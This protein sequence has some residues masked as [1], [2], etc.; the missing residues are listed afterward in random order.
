[1]RRAVV[2]ASVLALVVGACGGA[3]DG[4]DGAAGT[5]AVSTAETRGEPIVIKLSVVIADV[6]RAE[7]PATGEVLEGSTLGDAPFC[8]GGTIEDRH[9][10]EDPAMEPFGL[11]ARMI[12]CPDGTVRVGF[13]PEVTPGQPQGL[14]Q[15]GSWTIVSGTGTYERLRGSGEMETTYDPDGDSPAHETLTGTVTR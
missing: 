8:V 7:I 4:E 12:T 10:N 15:T 13:T 3:E 1:M 11:L 14:T 6:E 5:G 2:L 9:A